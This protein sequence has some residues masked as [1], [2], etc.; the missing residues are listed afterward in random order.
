MKEDKAKTAVSA[1]EVKTEK[2]EKKVRKD[3]KPGFF[4]RMGIKIKESFSELKKVSWPSFPKVVKQTGVVLLVVAIF[5]VIIGAFDFG[6]YELLKLV[7][8]K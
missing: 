6:L 8:P 4:K 1:K 7:S 3:G 2:K 5:L